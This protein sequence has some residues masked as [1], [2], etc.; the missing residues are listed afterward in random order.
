MRLFCWNINGIRA[1]LKKNLIQ[2]VLELE[3]DVLCLQEIKADPGIVVNLKK[4]ELSRLLEKYYFFFHSAEKKGYSGVATLVKKKIKVRKEFT[5]LDL[6]E[7]DQEG[8]ILGLSLEYGRYSFLL[9][10]I[11]F[12]NGRKNRERV[13]YKLSFY[14]ALFDYLEQIRESYKNKIIICGDYNTAHQ[15]IDLHDPRTN[16]KTSGFLREER[17]WLDL[18]QRKSYFDT[19]RYF[20][21]D[22]KDIYTWWDQR[23]RARERNKGWRIDYFFAREELK[24]SLKSAGIL[25][26]LEGSDHCPIFLELI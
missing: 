24:N 20:Y 2:K 5:K 9:F 13:D 15:E 8:R 18:I 25:D 26:K 19:F 4:K 22:Q 1:A 23:S 10:N 21:P 3:P 7:F 16:Q 12:P 11:Y 17:D 14:E 6:K